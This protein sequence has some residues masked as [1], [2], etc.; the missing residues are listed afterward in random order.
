M[1]KVGPAG[2]SATAASNPVIFFGRGLCHH[3][4]LGLVVG[5]THIDNGQGNSVSNPSGKPGGSVTGEPSGLENGPIQRS[6]V[7][8]LYR[9][10]LPALQNKKLPVP[11]LP[12]PLPDRGVDTE[13]RRMDEEGASLIQVTGASNPSPAAEASGLRCGLPAETAGSGGRLRFGRVF[14]QSSRST[15]QEPTFGKEAASSHL[16][17]RYIIECRFLQN[18]RML[19]W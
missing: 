18:F 1:K 17:Y 4:P 19:R 8:G 13:L 6:T 5:A 11:H 9:S 2:P 3:R 15:L 7:P 16:K 10:W 14:S 12:D